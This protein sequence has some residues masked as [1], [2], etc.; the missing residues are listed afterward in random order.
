M[1]NNSQLFVETFWEVDGEVCGEAVKRSDVGVV[2]R[3]TTYG[4][5]KIRKVERG[6]GRVVQILFFVISCQI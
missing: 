5:W 1:Q 4:L 2:R 3:S 6:E